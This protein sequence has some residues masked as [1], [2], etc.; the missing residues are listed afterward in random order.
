MASCPRFAS[1]SASLDFSI[2]V[3]K[4]GRFANDLTL[5]TYKR[6]STVPTDIWTPQPRREPEPVVEEPEAEEDI[7]PESRDAPSTPPPITGAAIGMGFGPSAGALGGALIA[8]L[9]IITLVL[10]GTPQG[11][12]WKKQ[13][14]R[15]YGLFANTLKGKWGRWRRGKF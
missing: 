4:Q 10:V 5:K 1:A 6:S 3:L 9:V 2:E 13:M 12:K 11:Q 14:G 7:S 15:E 8:V